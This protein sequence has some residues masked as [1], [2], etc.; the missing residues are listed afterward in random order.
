MVLDGIHPNQVVLMG[1][2]CG[3]SFKK[4][5]EDFFTIFPSRLESV[6]LSYFG[7]IVGVRRAL[8][9]ISF[10]PFMCLNATIADFC[11]RAPSTFVWSPVF[12]RDALVDDTIF[13][14]FLSKLSEISLH[15]S[16]GISTLKVFS[17]LNLII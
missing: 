11:Q 5:G 9:E 15:D 17:L 4:D 10:P 14:T 12:I 2:V 13:A 7:T 6:L 1:K 8:C 16:L 3:G